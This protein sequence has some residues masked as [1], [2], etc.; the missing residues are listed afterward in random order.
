MRRER[1]HDTT[2][3]VPFLVDKQRVF[4]CP[5]TFIAPLSFEYIKAFSFYDKGYLPST[6]G[7]NEQSN[8]YIQAMMILGNAFEK[9][10][11]NNGGNTNI[12]PSKAR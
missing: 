11:P 6:G 9:V 4:R 7:W 5:L 3:T 1:G 8:K 12:N 2:G 10:R